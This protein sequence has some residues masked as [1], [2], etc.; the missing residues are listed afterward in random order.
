MLRGA[1]SRL[2]GLFLHGMDGCRKG[3]DEI[4]VVDSGM[5]PALIGEA[6]A[7]PDRLKFHFM[8]S[9]N[10]VIEL[11]AESIISRKRS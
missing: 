8:D 3:W 7:V 1:D 6:I 9:S 2:Y 5:L 4:Q 11:S 10:E